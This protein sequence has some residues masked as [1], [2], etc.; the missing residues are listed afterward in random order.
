MEEENA[1][2]ETMEYRTVRRTQRNRRVGGGGGVLDL[3]FFRAATAVC[4][5]GQEEMMP[6]ETL[7]FSL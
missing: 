3:V 5:T 4:R 2:Q 1:M 7:G 6:Y